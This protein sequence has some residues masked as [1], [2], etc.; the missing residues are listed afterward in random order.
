MLRRAECGESGVWSRMA[1][2]ACS[3]RYSSIMSAGSKLP[4]SS[5]ASASTCIRVVVRVRAGVGTRLKERV[6]KHEG[7]DE[8]ERQGQGL[9]MVALANRSTVLDSSLGK[10]KWHL[11]S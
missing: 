1:R 5:H 7:E 11:H 9:V 8:G 2:P 3:S 10:R 4:R 6:S